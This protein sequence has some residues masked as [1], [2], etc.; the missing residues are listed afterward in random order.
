MGAS[1]REIA[2]WRLIADTTDRAAWSAADRAP[3]NWRRQCDMARQMGLGER[4]WR[5]IERALVRYGVLART[6][7]ENGYRGYRNGSSLARPLRAGLSLEPALAN[8]PALV[9]RLA[10]ADVAE[11]QR[12]EHILHARTARHRLGLLVA[13]LADRELRHWA[14]QALA[15]LEAELR[16]AVLRSAG[17]RHAGGLARRTARSG[18]PVAQ[19]G[20]TACL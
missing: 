5:N 11:A 1:E 14:Q 19:C 4:H 12:Q 2:V 18:G 16:P 9:M 13:G 15:T 20:P 7:A 3:L 6:T 17:P 10:E 8:Y